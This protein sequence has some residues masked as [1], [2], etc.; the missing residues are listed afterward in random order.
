MSRF[1]LEITHPRDQSG[2][3]CSRALP[4][5]GTSPLSTGTVFEEDARG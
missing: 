5:S 4:R 3:K 1:P 2:S